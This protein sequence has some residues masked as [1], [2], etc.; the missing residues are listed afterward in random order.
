M[1][2][3]YSRMRLTREQRSALIDVALATSCLTAIN[4]TAHFTELASS[5]ATVPLGVAALVALALARGYTPRSLGL[6]RHTVKRGL[7]WAFG[8][9]AL[10]AAVAGVGLTLPW[11]RELFLNEAYSNLRRALAA[12]LIIIPLQTVVPEELAFRGVLHS[13]LDKLGGTK[14]VFLGGS[15]FFGLW[16]ISSSLGLTASNAGLRAILGSGHAAQWIGVGLAVCATGM[17]G[18]VFTWLRHHTNSVMAPIGLHW[19]LNSIGALAAAAAWMW[20]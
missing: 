3:R 6:S 19:A 1:V 12:A 7:R 16:H 4:T 5:R 9:A 13:A 15:V 18:A 11:T 14:G 8:S 2:A 20:F 17:A 10:V